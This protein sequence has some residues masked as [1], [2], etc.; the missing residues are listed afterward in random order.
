[1]LLDISNPAPELSKS[2]FQSEKVLAPGPIAAHDSFSLASSQPL[3]LQCFL[4]VA[5]Q[6]AGWRMPILLILCLLQG[7]SQTQP[8]CRA[9][10]TRPES[11]RLQGPLPGTSEAFSPPSVVWAYSWLSLLGSEAMQRIQGVV[12]S[13]PRWSEG[14]ESSQE[15]SHA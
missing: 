13:G 7:E 15:R 11:S 5:N 9:C 6:R 3:H 14:G 10:K 4:Q 2:R 8:K 1:M 12:R